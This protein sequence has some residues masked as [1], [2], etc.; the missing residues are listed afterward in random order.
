MRNLFIFLVSTI[1]LTACGNNNNNKETTTKQDDTTTKST[2]NIQ[3]PNKKGSVNDIISSYLDLKNALVNDDREGA[4]SAASKI[5]TAVANV[6][7]SGLSAD[8]KKAYDEVKDDIN[9]HAEHIGSASSNI[10]H[11]REHFELLSQD[12]ID[13]VNKTG[14]TKALYKDFCPMYN[15]NKGA[16]W[17]SETR[18]IKN[19]YY[20]SK[21]PKCGEVKE[22][23]VP[24]G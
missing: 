21:M 12:V 8:Q 14:S 1:V 20:G 23:I 3:E 13:L 4:A 2:T 10:E 9:E 17:I 22:A 24:K 16:W 18:E 15:N 7:G 19:P 11:Q 5:G 6:D